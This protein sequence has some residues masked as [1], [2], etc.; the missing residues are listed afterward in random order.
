M[1]IKPVIVLTDDLSEGLKSDLAAVLGMSLESCNLTWWVST[2]RPEEAS[3]SVMVL[4]A[5][6]R[7]NQAL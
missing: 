6:Q 3:R 7:V 1:W 4:A 5:H 2:T